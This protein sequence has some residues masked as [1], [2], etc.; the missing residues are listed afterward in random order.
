V[1]LDHESS[2]ATQLTRRE[3][4][5][6]RLTHQGLNSKEIGALL[7]LSPHTIDNHVKRALNRLGVSDRRVAARMVAA[8]EASDPLVR[9]WLNQTLAMVRAGGEVLHHIAQEQQ[10][11]AARESLRRSQQ[12]P[13]AAVAADHIDHGSPSRDPGTWGYSLK[14]HGQF[15]DR[16]PDREGLFSFRTSIGHGDPRH[17]RDPQA[18]PGF[19][20]R[21][22]RSTGRPSRFER[23]IVVIAAVCGLL[24]T[25]TLVINGLTLLLHTIDHQEP[26]S[27]GSH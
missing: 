27:H 26:T 14:A 18:R 5:C 16:W 13:S 7:S 25:A 8:E 10:D 11:E 1:G 17:R 21:L 19:W 20:R 6:L 3:R 23:L 9:D 2:P 4:E 22:F 15:S 12:L 24:M